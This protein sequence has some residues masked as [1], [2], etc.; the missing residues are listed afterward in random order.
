MSDQIAP[1]KTDAY[2]TVTFEKVQTIEIKEA[3]NAQNKAPAAGKACSASDQVNFSTPMRKHLIKQKS[4]FK[5]QASGQK[6]LQRAQ[7]EAQHK[8][9]SE[10]V[11]SQAQLQNQLLQSTGLNQIV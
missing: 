1:I 9:R 4:Y 8:P 10:A 11:Q 2:G 3:D 7:Q 6:Q 5:R